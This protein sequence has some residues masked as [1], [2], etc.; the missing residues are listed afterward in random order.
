MKEEL[1]ISPS[2]KQIIDEYM[3][4]SLGGKKVVCPYYMNVIKERAGLSAL[5]GKGDP[6]DIEKEVKVWAKLKDFDLNKATVEQIRQF[7]IDH[8]IGVDCSGFIVN[9]F[10]HWFKTIGKK[11]LITYLK[12]NRNSIM[13]RL[14]RLIRPVENIGANTITSLQNTIP[15][16]KFDDVLPGDFIR[17]KGKVKNSHHISL[18]TKVIK[19]DGHVKEVEYVHSTRHFASQNGVR[20]G[21]IRITNADKPLSEQN[22]IEGG[23]KVNSTLQGF[24]NMEEDN[25]IRRLKCLV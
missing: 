1:T 7:M 21:K 19:V 12:F 24:K 16:T 9:I 22:W 25:G 8:H 3:N 18:I 6:S 13:L 5:I 20:Y 14:K 15:I 23:R 4:L 10:N 11:P 2:A 17:S